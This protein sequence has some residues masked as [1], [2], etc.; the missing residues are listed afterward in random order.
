MEDVFTLRRARTY[1]AQVRW[2]YAK[3]MPQWPHEYT[4]RSWMPRLEQQFEAIV[5]FIRD[6]GEVRHWPNASRNPR[7]HNT[8]LEIDGWQYWTM[9]EPIKETT[10]LNRARVGGPG[11]A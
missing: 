2:Q 10:V 11:A 8:Y 5:R 4:I 7:Y 1:I 3:T 9:G 6:N